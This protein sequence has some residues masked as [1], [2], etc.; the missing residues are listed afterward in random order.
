MVAWEVQPDSYRTTF[1]SLWRFYTVFTSGIELWTEIGLWVLCMTY[2]SHLMKCVK[3]KLLAKLKV[4]VDGVKVVDSFAHYHFTYPVGI[5]L[6]KSNCSIP[7]SF[8]MQLVFR[9][10]G[11]ERLGLVS[12]AVLTLLRLKLLA[13]KSKLGWVDYQGLVLLFNQSSI[14][15]IL[16]MTPLTSR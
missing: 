5:L 10:R 6:L 9:K 16:V 4:L 12:C 2:W 7:N 15:H 11:R 14:L 3:R 8:V 1:I 13:W